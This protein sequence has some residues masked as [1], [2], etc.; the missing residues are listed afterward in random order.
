MSFDSFLLQT[1]TAADLCRALWAI[2]E[3][4]KA[5]ICG[6]SIE[7][8]MYLCHKAPSLTLSANI[9]SRPQ[10]IEN[11]F[12]W[13]I[14]AKSLRIASHLLEF[15]YRLGSK[16][17]IRDRIPIRSVQMCL[18]LFQ[19]IFDFLEACCYGP[20]QICFQ[21]INSHFGHVHCGCHCNAN[22]TQSLSPGDPRGRTFAHHWIRRAV[23]VIL[24]KVLLAR[25][26]SW[27]YKLCCRATAAGRLLRKQ[28]GF[29][30]ALSYIWF[31]VGC[32]LIDLA[33]ARPHLPSFVLNESWNYLGKGILDLIGPF[34]NSTVM[35]GDMR[36]TW[37]WH[38]GYRNHAWITYL[39]AM[40]DLACPRYA[41]AIGFKTRRLKRSWRARAAG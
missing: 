29:S 37:T 27:H 32:F 17:K 24:F 28:K 36:G 3:E 31:D 12:D 26:R 14:K 35:Y 4:Y 18:Y 19:S 40:Q 8:C 7:G 34:L 15:V 1:W 11:P 5:H 21:A 6:I 25:T 10:E 13:K 30:R 33:L 20:C 9:G 39:Q 38:D 2:L 41:H 22:A 23:Y 16:T